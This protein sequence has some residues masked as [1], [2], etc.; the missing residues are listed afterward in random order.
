M[1]GRQNDLRIL[2]Q[3]R[4][5]KFIEKTLYFYQMKKASRDFVRNA[6]EYR[7]PSNARQVSS[8]T[9]RKFSRKNCAKQTVHF[10]DTIPPPDFVSRHTLLSRLIFPSVR[11]VTVFPRH[12]LFR[13][14]D[15]QAVFR[16]TQC[17]VPPPKLLFFRFSSKSTPVPGQRIDAPSRE[18]LF[19]GI[20]HSTLFLSRIKSVRTTSPFRYDRSVFSAPKT[21]LLFPDKY[22]DRLLFRASFIFF[23]IV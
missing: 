6:F 18:L 5:Q 23:E 7:T 13:P 15:L 12:A 9:V 21:K 1:T 3:T 14:R 4:K 19:E 10:P 16:A 20:R 22:K 2:P 17:E 8:A 11:G